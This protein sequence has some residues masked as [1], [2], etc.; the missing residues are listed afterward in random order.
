MLFLMTLLGCGSDIVC[1]EGTREVDGE[2][3]PNPVLDQT[4][5]ETETFGECEGASF[6]QIDVE[7]NVTLVN[8]KEVDVALYGEDTV[9][10]TCTLDETTIADEYDYSAYLPAGGEWRYLDAGPYP[11]DEWFTTEFDDSKWPSG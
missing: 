7:S 2:C 6:F 8:A 9:S 3:L 10:I 5:T 11:G 1:G 4:E